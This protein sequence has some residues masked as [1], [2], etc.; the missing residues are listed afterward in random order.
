MRLMRWG[1][2]FRAEGVER[3]YPRGA[4]RRD[5]GRDEGDHDQKHGDDAVGERVGRAGIEENGLELG[6]AK[7][8]KQ[9]ALS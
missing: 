5:K 6:P 8:A 7:R 4:L 9:I 3:V 2:L 1:E